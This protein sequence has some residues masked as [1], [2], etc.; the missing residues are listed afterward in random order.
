VRAAFHRYEAAALRIASARSLPQPTLQFGVFVQSVETRVGPQQARLSVA[1]SFPWPSTL[2]ANGK[3]ADAAAQAAASDLAASTLGVVREAAEAYWNLWEV[4]TTRALHIEHVEVMAGLTATVRSRVETGTASLAD[5]QQVELS[6]ARLADRIAT[7][8]ADERARIAQLEALT[9]PLDPPHTPADPPLARP[10]L[11]PTDLRQAVLAHPAL[12][13]L[14]HRTTSAERT[15]RAQK[16]N[17]LPG[18]TVGGDWLVTGEA[19]TTGVADSGKDAVQITAGVQVPL[20]QRGLSNA[21]KAA[22]HEALARRQDHRASTD[23]ALAALTPTL[24]ALA[25]SERRVVTLEQTL[26]PLSE[27]AYA[28]ILGNYTVGDGSVAQP[29]LAQRD[30]LDLAVDLQ[31]ARADHQRAW[32]RLHQLLGGPTPHT[33][34]PDPAP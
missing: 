34:V 26:L 7:M 19:P 4:R 29:L 13:S 3:A 23:R 33:S 14:E 32:A 10:A 21:S 31:H 18:F 30:L 11:D 12:A 2:V 22:N 1:Q 20:W 6:R 28:S 8:D 25:D 9:G 16:G 17:R 24:T 5:L 27:A 15:A